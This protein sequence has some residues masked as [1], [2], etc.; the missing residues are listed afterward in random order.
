MKTAIYNNLV[1]TAV[2]VSN[3]MSLVQKV[4]DRQV[5]ITCRRRAAKRFAQTA[6]LQ[7][8]AHV[9]AP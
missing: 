8:D 4:V 5:D 2:I 1:K 9:R 3:P 7:G 6:N